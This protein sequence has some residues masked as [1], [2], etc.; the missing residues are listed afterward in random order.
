MMEDMY[1]GTHLLTYLSGFFKVK[2]LRLW[3]SGVEGFA[4]RIP[5]VARLTGVTHLMVLVKAGAGIRGPRP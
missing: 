4:C 3:F 1:L 2:T 5:L